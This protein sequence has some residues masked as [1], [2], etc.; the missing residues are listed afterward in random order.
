MIL[1]ANEKDTH[2]KTIWDA[3]DSYRET[4]DLLN[5]PIDD[6]QWSDICTAMAW[7]TING[8]S[9]DDTFTR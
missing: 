5:A 4:C 3:L 1:I 7:L 6:N 9:D 2:I 8:R